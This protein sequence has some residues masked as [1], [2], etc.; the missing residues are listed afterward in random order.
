MKNF[1]SFCIKV[2]AILLIVI[3][4]IPDNYA[5][6]LNYAEST[7]FL[8]P[9]GNNGIPVLNNGITNPTLY[10]PYANPLYSNIN[11][12]QHPAPQNE[13]AVK[14]NRKYQNVVLAAYR[15]FRYGVE[16]SAMRRVGYS[17]STDMGLTWSVSTL[18]DSTLIPDEPRNSD[19]VIGCDSAG[20]FYIGVIALNTINTNGYLLVYKSTDKGVTFPFAYTVASSSGT[21]EDKEYIANDLVQGS[22]YYNSIYFS[23]TRILGSTSARVM[24]TKS[25]NGGVNWTT[26]VAVSDLSS[27]VQGSQ[28]VISTNGQVN[29]L[30]V[31]NN[32]TDAIVYFD[33]STDG[34]VTFGTDVIISTGSSPYG[35][36]NNASTFPSIAADVSGGIRNG[37]LYSVFCD[38]RNGDPDVFLSRSTNSGNNWSNPVRINNDSIGNGKV[39]FWPWI[40]VNETGNIAVIWYD[41]RNT[42]TNSIV[43]AY[44]GRS[45]DGGLTFTN[46]LLSTQ[47]SPTNVSGSTVRFGDYICVDYWANK[48]IPVWTDE[49]I[50]GVNMEIFTAMYPLVKANSI[51]NNIPSDFSIEQNYP[52]P[53]NPSTTIRFLVKESKLILIKVYDITG[54][55][56]STIINDILSPGTYE[57]KF[58]A[59]KLSS[60]VYFYTLF[61]DGI[62]KDTKKMVLI[63]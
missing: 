11:I 49:R 30:W 12:T 23:W 45:S 35:L 54:K 60:G 32:G 62:R 7:M 48:I 5:Q 33:K 9:I 29:I 19:P 46:E 38:S 14:I 15:D 21:G 63:K 40:S 39:Q 26:P 3:V 55:E 51:S 56:I 53:F 43:E 16:P 17:Y 59:G 42:A 50:D 8:V 47:P 27:G 57:T 1:S 37:Y 25:T 52:N 34:G 10:A 2:L 4:F 18:L 36:P 41:T 61:A 20:N 6:I 28:P 44:L 31:K 13:P 24:C 22:P 58:D